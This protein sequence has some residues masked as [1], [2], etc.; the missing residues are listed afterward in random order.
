MTEPVL[1]TEEEEGVLTLWLNRPA[2]RNALNGALV[3]ALTGALAETRDRDD[4]KVIVL[5]GRGP[6]FCA[7]ADLKELENSMDQGPEAN[8]ADARR[9]GALLLAMRRHP[10]PVVAAVRGKAL[11]GG[12]GLATACDL[13]LAEETAEFGYPEVHLGFVPAMVMAIL[14]KKVTE[15]RAFELVTRGRLVSAAEAREL[16]LVNRVFP[17]SVFE[18]ELESFVGDLARRPASAVALTKGLLYEL[19]DLTMPEGIERGARVN[20]EARRTEA[21]RAGV[22]AFLARKERGGSG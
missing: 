17:V 2:K 3:E 20:V 19:A 15:G 6:D 14:R 11:A 21:C 7:G 12:C 9:L 10:K 18:E 5:R 4:V 8:L 22:E 16:G 13:I 1:R